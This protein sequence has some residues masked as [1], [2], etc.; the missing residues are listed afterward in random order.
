MTV[1]DTDIWAAFGVKKPR[2]ARP[3]RKPTRKIKRCPAKAVIEPNE[4]EQPFPNWHGHDDGTFRAW[5]QANSLTFPDPQPEDSLWAEEDSWWPQ[6]IKT[7]SNRGI[8]ELGE[9]HGTHHRIRNHLRSDR[10]TYS[11]H[12]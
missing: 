7:A 10:R 4:Q 1:N 12:S 5:V 2:T 11:D 3:K 9:Q 8:I 6:G